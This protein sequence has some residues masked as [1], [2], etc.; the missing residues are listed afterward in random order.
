[1]YL[2]TIKLSSLKMQHNEF[3]IQFIF[4]HPK[5]L[6]Y[7]IRKIMKINLIKRMHKSRVFKFEVGS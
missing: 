1:M 5:M 4:Y 2:I 7:K 3:V 6:L